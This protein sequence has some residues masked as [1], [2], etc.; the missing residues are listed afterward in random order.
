M[1]KQLIKN[2]QELRSISPKADWKQVN[3]DVLFNQLANTLI[4]RPDKF[5]V[6]SIPKKVFHFMS[7]PAFV[8]FCVCLVVVSL[9]GF[10][11][12]RNTKPGDSLYIAKRISEKAQLVITFNE[13]KKDQLNF[14][15]A[16][17]HAKEITKVLASFDF[18]NDDKEKQQKLSDDFKKEIGSVKEQLVRMGG[19]KQEVAEA[20]A[21]EKQ[22]EDIIIDNNETSATSASQEDEQVYTADFSRDNQG[23]QVSVDESLEE[24]VSKPTEELVVESMDVQVEEELQTV[25]DEEV[26][27]EIITAENPNNYDNAQK[28][29]REAEE[30]FDKQDYSGALDKL[31]EVDQIVE[32]EGADSDFEIQTEGKEILEPN[33]DE[34]SIEEASVEVE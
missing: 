11:F 24:E 32:R 18:N 15:F 6:L 28:K 2:L 22:G 4:E 17:E 20:D 9:L 21:S 25:A 23:V 33:T 19:V 31:E 1:E 8:V 5:S 16:S 30:L 3:R 34:V 12:S 27:A 26:V 14:K 13:E 10:Q 7:Q 29:L